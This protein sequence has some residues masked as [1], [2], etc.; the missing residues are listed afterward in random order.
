VTEERID[1]KKEKNPRG[2]NNTVLSNSFGLPLEEEKEK[3]HEIKIV[4]ELSEKSKEEENQIESLKDDSEME[5]LLEENKDEP[6][7]KS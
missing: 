7:S 1:A 3:G 2:R 4:E 6:D 5:D